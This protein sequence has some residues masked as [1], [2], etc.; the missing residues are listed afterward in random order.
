[1]RVQEVISEN[2]KKRYMLLDEEGRPEVAVL[3]YLKYLDAVQK[4]YNTKERHTALKDNNIITLSCL[5]NKTNSLS[6]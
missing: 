5:F 1:M 3:K 2:N 6:K 4:S